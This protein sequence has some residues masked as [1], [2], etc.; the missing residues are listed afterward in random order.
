MSRLSPRSLRLQLLIE[1]LSRVG[2]VARNGP[3]LGSPGGRGLGVTWGRL[4]TVLAADGSGSSRVHTVE[5]G[6]RANGRAPDFDTEVMTC[7]TA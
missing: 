4:Q 1:F 3:R 6:R 7:R 5:H 2:F